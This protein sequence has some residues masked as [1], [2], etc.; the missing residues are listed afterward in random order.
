MPTLYLTEQGSTL[1]KEGQRLEVTKG[2]QLLLSVPAL[3]VERI[4][5]LLEE[6]ETVPELMGVEGIA[7]AA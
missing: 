4:M 1:R 7:S 5:V 2:E 3:R 6:Q